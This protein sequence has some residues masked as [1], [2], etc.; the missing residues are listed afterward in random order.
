MVLVGL[1]GLVRNTIISATVFNSFSSHL[2]MR[3]DLV[4][5]TF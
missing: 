5:I 4:T 3:R 1:G 2:T